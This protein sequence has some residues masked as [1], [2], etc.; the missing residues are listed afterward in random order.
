MWTAKVLGVGAVALALSVDV[1][2]RL[3]RRLRSRGTLKEVLFFPSEIACVEHI[4][5]PALPQ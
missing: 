5:R 1:T 2:V 4:F 3:I